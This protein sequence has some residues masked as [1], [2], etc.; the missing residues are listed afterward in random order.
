MR[1]CHY[2]PNRAYYLSM[3]QQ[4]MIYT[5]QKKKC[6]LKVFLLLILLFPVAAES[7]VIKEPLHILQEMEYV[8]GKYTRKSAL[9][10]ELGIPP[11]K[12][13]PSRE[14]L[15][16]YLADK[17]QSLVN[18]RV[19]EEAEYRL[20]QI[21]SL[22]GATIYRGIILVRGSWPFYLIPYPKFDSNSGFRGGLKIFYNNF[23]G[24]LSNFYLG[25][26]IDIRP[27]GGGWEIPQWTINPRIS[28]ITLFGQKFSLD[29]VQ[30]YQETSKYDSEKEIY[31]ERYNTYK[32]GIA[33]TTS[34]QLPLSLYYS[35]TPQFAFTYGFKDKNPD[36]V[37]PYEQQPMDFSFSHS[38]GRSRINWIG[39]FRKGLSF[40]LSQ[41]LSF[42]TG[43]QRDGNLRTSLG[44]SI[45]GFYPWKILNPSFRLQG[46]YS[47]FDD[48][49]SGLG[50]KLRGIR[51]DSFYGIAGGFL[52]TSINISVIRWQ[53]VG[54]AQFQPFLRC[55]NRL[56]EGCR[57]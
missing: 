41:S 44:A 48:E 35:F 22:D 16:A 4:E 53:G 23:V 57:L 54:E 34:L 21:D 2:F 18:L 52:N 9:I 30:K 46:V 47:F 25:M 51:D 5:Y 31:L 32:T 37:S 55:G 7:I 20:E 39:N 42:D 50:G 27:E 38:V 36:G 6:L 45:T 1:Y 13:F 14:E 49:L 40:N 26:N 3:P 24:T 56:K 28:N 12:T 33:L 15:E 29:L 43:E 8:T 17:V 11:E 19:F 10:R